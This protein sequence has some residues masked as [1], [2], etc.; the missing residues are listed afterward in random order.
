MPT[1]WSATD[2]TT[3][4]PSERTL[5]PHLA[6]VGAE[7][8]R[9]VD[10]VDEDL[11]EARLVAADR[12][13]VGLRRDDERDALAVGEQPEPLGRAL[14]ERAEVDVVSEHERPPL[15]IRARSSSSLT[16]WTRWPVST[17]IFVIRS[18][19]RAGTSG[20]SAS[21]ASVSA[22][23]LTVVS[24]VRSSCDRLS[25]NSARICWR[26]RSSETSSTTTSRPLASGRWTRTTSTRGS[27]SPTLTSPVALPPIGTPLMSP[28]AR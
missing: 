12:R 4:T 8:D 22:S 6:A 25:M 7:L 28:S 14:G 1:P 11:A 21:R 9:V 13:H 15:S 3:S 16:I 10:E 19:I 18:R 2:D 27:R 26:R 17:S 23:R 20:A 24:G 5:D